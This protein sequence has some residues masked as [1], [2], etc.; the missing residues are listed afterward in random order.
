ME[1]DAFESLSEFSEDP[2][3]S[4]T[5]GHIGIDLVWGE[6][7]GLVPGFDRAKGAVNDIEVCDIE[8]FQRDLRRMEIGP[9]F[10]VLTIKGEI[11]AFSANTVE[12]EWR[13]GMVGFKGLVD[14]GRFER[15]EVDPRDVMVKRVM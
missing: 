5:D 4:I 9:C 12:E 14:D 2:D 7:G 1:P 11:G 3:F 6:P 10:E 13:P 8:R 15:L